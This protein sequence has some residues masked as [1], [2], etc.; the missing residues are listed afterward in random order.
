VSDSAPSEWDLAA[1]SFDDEPDHGLRNPELRSAWIELLMKHL[2]DPPA[3]LLDLGCGTGTLSVLLASMGF[4][5]TG[6][7]SSAG[8]LDQ[9]KVK[10]DREG[11]PVEFV[12]GDAASPPVVGTFDVLLCRHVLWALPDLAG[13]LTCWR[14][15][16]GPGGRLVL[17]EGLWSTGAGIAATDLVP[18]VERIIGKSRLERL[19]D[20]ALWGKAISDERYLGS[21]HCVGAVRCRG[22]PHEVTS[23]LAV[24]RFSGD[25]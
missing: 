6:V 20:E 23:A 18:T 16:L 11:F 22:A 4:T 25:V 24:A 13:A 9:A 21:G 15:F 1:A 7:D 19:T 2:P 14:S 3:T 17:I 12:L 8:M 5:V 10:A